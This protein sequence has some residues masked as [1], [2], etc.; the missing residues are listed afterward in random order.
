MSYTI[1]LLQDDEATVGLWLGRCESLHRS[2]R[3]ALAAEYEGYLRRM[4]SE[5]A[6][7]AVLHEGEVP[8][9][10]TIFRVQQTTF[11]G[12]RCYVDDL[13]TIEGERGKG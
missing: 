10:V 7:M 11:H 4:F 9:A 5:G 2:L 8:K 3:P 12:R 1:H 13:V 6:R